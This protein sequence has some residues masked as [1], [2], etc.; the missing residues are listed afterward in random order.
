MTALATGHRAIAE[1]LRAL[2]QLYQQGQASELL[3][4]TLNKLLAYEADTARVQLSQ[5]QQDLAELEQRHSLSSAEF[6]RRYR[7]GQ[8]DDR[9][10]FVEW[11]A[12]VQMA[13]NLQERLRMLSGEDPA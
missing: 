12:L 5:L 1:R 13:D 2:A 9:M 4:R 11:A 6:Y 7:A 3:E 8:T 10:D